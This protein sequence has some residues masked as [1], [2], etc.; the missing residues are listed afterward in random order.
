MSC[1][2]SEV[3]PKLEHLRLFRGPSW[4]RSHAGERSRGFSRIPN[5]TGRAAKSTIGNM[6]YA[7]LTANAAMADNITLFHA[8]HNNLAAVA[9]ALTVESATSRVP[10]WRSRRTPTASP[11]A[12]STSGRSS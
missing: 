11:P 12:A 7:V 9:A 5:R 1:S 6:V 2:P 8:D 4:W 10:A 3:P